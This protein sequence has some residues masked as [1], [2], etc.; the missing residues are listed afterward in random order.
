M[1][2]N[3]NDSNVSA[4][5]IV[6]RR[7]GMYWERIALGLL[8]F[9]VTVM[10]LAYQSHQADFKELSAKVLNLQMEKVSRTDLNEVEQRI[11]KNFDARIGELISRSTADKQDILA[12]IDLY[13]KNN[14]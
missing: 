2:D 11:N 3:H 10:F 1:T 13:F 14:K 12:R 9:V 7:I 8:S 6:D 4:A 5:V